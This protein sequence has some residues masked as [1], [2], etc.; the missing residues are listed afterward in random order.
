M[1]LKRIF[2]L[3]ISAFIIKKIFLFPTTSFLTTTN[4]IYTHGAGITAA[5]GHCYPTT[6]TLLVGLP[7]TVLWGEHHPV[8]AVDL[9]SQWIGLSLKLAPTPLESLKV[10]LC[11]PTMAA[12]ALPCGST[13]SLTFLPSMYHYVHCCVLNDCSL[14]PLGGPR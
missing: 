7:S 13:L 11:P 2:S 4:L 8:T 3:K 5:A 9:V 6:H 12:L 10:R 14:S 1:R